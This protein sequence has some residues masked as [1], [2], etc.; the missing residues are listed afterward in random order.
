[1]TT[2]GACEGSER[3]GIWRRRKNRG[4]DLGYLSDGDALEVGVRALLE[5]A[6][7]GPGGV[8][9]GVAER[10]RRILRKERRRKR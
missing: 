5:E 4:A 6:R 1:M 8:H 10:R 9:V 2:P 3:R 7:L